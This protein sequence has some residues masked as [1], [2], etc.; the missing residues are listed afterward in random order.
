MGG[1]PPSPIC[2]RHI[3]RTDYDRIRI[4]AAYLW[5]WCSPTAEPQVSNRHDPKYPDSPIGYC[6]DSDSL[7]ECGRD[8]SKVGI[9]ECGL[10]GVPLAQPFQLDGRSAWQAAPQH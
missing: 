8:R 6:E 5:E 7:H 2:T 3:G 10:H 4:C 1:P 9:H